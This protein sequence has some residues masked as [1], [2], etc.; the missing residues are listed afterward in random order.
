[1]RANAQ[2]RFKIAT[3]PAEFEQIHALNYRTFV[4]EIPQHRPNPAGILVDKFHHENTYLI[5]LDGDHLAGMMAVRDKRP[6]SLD[7]KLENLDDYLPPGRK[8]CELRLLAVEKGYRTGQVLYGMMG[9]LADYAQEY[10]HTLA[11]ISGT[12]RQQKLYQHIGFV[13]FGPLVGSEEAQFQ[14][15]YLTLETAVENFGV[16]FPDDGD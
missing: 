14:P 8:V 10:G 16:F 12:I 13:P 15:M 11:I 9:L 2:L 1:M 5:A 7:Q 6:F 3:E 4:E